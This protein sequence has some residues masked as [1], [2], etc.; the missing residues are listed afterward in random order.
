MSIKSPQ[1]FHIQKTKLITNYLLVI[2]VAIYLTACAS[3]KQASSIRIAQALKATSE[4][5]I[6]KLYIASEQSA[7]RSVAA[8]LPLFILLGN[9]GKALPF[10]IK[11]S[12]EEKYAKYIGKIGNQDQ[13]LY[14][15]LDPGSYNIATEG[16]NLFTAISSENSLSGKKYLRA[17]EMDIEYSYVA[18]SGAVDIMHC[19]I[20][21]FLDGD[22]KCFPKQL[23]DQNILHELELTQQETRRVTN[24]NYKK[25][26]AKAEWQKKI[27]KDYISKAKPINSYHRITASEATLFEMP[28]TT[29]N[30]IVKL[31]QVDL[32][33]V[34]HKIQGG[35]YLISENGKAQGWMHKSV[36]KQDKEINKASVK[37]E[38]S[39][40]A[41]IKEKKRISLN[42]ARAK[43]IANE[44]STS[45]SNS[46]ADCATYIAKKQACDKLG[47]F[48]SMACMAVVSDKNG[49]L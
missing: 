49:C 36:L 6:A 22:Q 2:T 1:F 48:G 7:S 32:V 20:S 45:S 35:W 13:M 28:N 9:P 44:A 27:Q 18:K 29:S 10:Y 5:G 17:D 12:E 15:E 19:S 39:V 8:A 23:N 46:V 24:E 37:G 25:S 3:G 16:K 47:Y 11:A 31:R 38:L 33:F 42:L 40:L 34:S 41:R 4:P 14:L 26:I 21:E 30:N 43:S